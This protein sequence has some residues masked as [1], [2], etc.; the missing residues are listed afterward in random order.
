[1]FDYLARDFKL[2]RQEAIQWK[3]ADG[4]TVEG[5]LTYPVDYAPGQRYPLAVITH[6]GQVVH[7]ATQKAMQPAAARA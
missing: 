3:G 2:G 4:V 5:L 1:M 6:G 7:E